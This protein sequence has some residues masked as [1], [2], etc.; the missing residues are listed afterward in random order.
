[1]VV[2]SGATGLPLASFFAYKEN[3]RGGVNVTA[4][5][6]TGDGRADILVG[7][8]TGGGPRVRL[9]DLSVGR[10]MPDNSGA[11]TNNSGAVPD[12]SGADLSGTARPTNL[13][14]TARPTNFFA[15]VTNG[16]RVPVVD[17][18]IMNYF[19]QSHIMKWDTK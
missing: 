4:A 6:F 18:P 3:F 14:G 7:A 1:M 16:D 19:L 12:N 8:G 9:F 10:A 5:D 11:G 15:E 17:P 2:F 13:S